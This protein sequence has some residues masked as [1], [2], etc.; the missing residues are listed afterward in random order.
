VGDLYTIKASGA[1]TNG[2]FALIEAI[3]PPGSGPPPHVHRREDEAFYVLEGTLRFHAD[4]HTFDAGP[5]G[6]ITLAKGSPH[7]FENVSSAPAR[8]LILVTPAGLD[9]FFVEVGRPAVTRSPEEGRPTPEDI[10]RLLE[11]APR[12]GLE[13]LPPPGH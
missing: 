13:I 1:D 8:M 11:A 12:Y 10:A 6:W 5:G 4:G 9:A 3:V 2:A 7:R